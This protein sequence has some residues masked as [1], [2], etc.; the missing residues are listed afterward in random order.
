MSGKIVAKKI[1]QFDTRGM[2]ILTLNIKKVFFDQIVRGEKKIE[3]RELKQTTLNRYTY[4]D[5]ADGNDI[6]VD[7]MRYVFCWLQER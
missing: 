1:S 3:Y 6:Y 4:V 5:E 2:K 7:M